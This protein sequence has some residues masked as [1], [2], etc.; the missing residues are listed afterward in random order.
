M[1]TDI[2]YVAL[3]C[4]ATVLN[5]FVCA[6]MFGYFRSQTQRCWQREQEASRCVQLTK[7]IALLQDDYDRLRDDLFEARQTIAER[8]LAR[9]ELEKL[10]EQIR[11]LKD[12]LQQL[13]ERR[14]ELERVKR[15]LEERRD[16]LADVTQRKLDLDQALHIAELRREELERTHRELTSQ[17]AGL[18]QT[19]KAETTHVAELRNQIQSLEQQ[20]RDA[21]SRREDVERQIGRLQSEAKAWEEKNQRKQKDLEVAS[22]KLKDVEGTISI[23]TGERNAL[24]AETQTQRRIVAELKGEVGEL[25]AQLPTLKNMWEALSTKIGHA[26][27]KE[28]TAELWNPVFPRKEF[29]HAPPTDE[30]KQLENLQ[31]HLKRCGLRFHR[32]VL[33]AFH[34]A[35]KVNDI[36]PLVVLAGISGTGKSELPRRYAEAMGMHFLNLAVQP[37]W[38][39]PQDMFG[40]FNYLDGRYRAT[41]LGRALIQMDPYHEKKDWGQPKESKD[42][43]LHKQMLLVLLDEMNLARI[44]Y[45]FSEFLSRLEMRRGIDLD[46]ADYREKAEIPLEVGRS[47]TTGSVMRVFVGQNVF[48]VGTMNEDETTQTLSDKV[49][50]RANVLRFGPPKKLTLDLDSSETPEGLGKQRLAYEHWKSRYV[51][52]PSKL[53]PATRERIDGWLHTLNEAMR[54]IRR[55]FAYRVSRAMEAYIANY[56]HVDGEPRLTWALADQIEQKLLPKFRGLDPADADVQEALGTIRKLIQDEDDEPLLKAIDDSE[57][58]H[59]FVWQGVNRDEADE[60]QGA[61]AVSDQPALRSNSR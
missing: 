10:A 2:F 9:R 56:P 44:E 50:D 40:F 3:G 54:Q 48:F 55:P 43:S 47:G 27:D 39:S 13:D 11:Q 59:Q 33:Y 53:D 35:L 46:Q 7:G 8:E 41:E 12:E 5:A 42:N 21:E 45:Y 30:F 61:T 52:D 29:R 32:R 31:D 17:L 4:L 58:A 26:T 14:N 28:R 57:V 16:D 23:K 6:L 49:V 22:A 24:D 19:I 51:R 1:A 25:K 15:E 37:R 18:S 36:S 38:D 34:T 60:Q 20:Q